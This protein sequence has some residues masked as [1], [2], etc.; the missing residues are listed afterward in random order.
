MDGAARLARLLE[1]L[2][3]ASLSQ[4]F[5]EVGYA[6]IPG[7]LAAR[8]CRQID[9]LYDREE[10][11]RKRVDMGR[12]QFGEGEYQYFANP[13]PA[14]VEQLRRG[15]Y[16][17]LAPIANLWQERLRKPE[18]FPDSLDGFIRVCREAGQER[19]TPLLL[20]Y[21]A[22]GY[23]RLHQDLYGAISFP[24]QVTILL[25]QPGRDYEGGEFLLTEQRARLQSRGEAIALEQGEAI[26]FATRERPVTSVRGFARAQLRH[27]V[28]RIRRGRRSAL[29][30]I[31]H[32]AK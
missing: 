11:F 12:H 19:P 2:D 26:V 23:N 3:W 7:L 22:D 14:L 28:S 16:P 15:L 10:L 17:A 8:S 24:L 31:F 1:S 9:A 4:Q 29:G 20:R 6:R 5:D 21:E 25:S 13:L 32:D 27:G 18:R 30:I